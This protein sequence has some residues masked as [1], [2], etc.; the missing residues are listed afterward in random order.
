MAKYIIRGGNKLDGKIEAESA[1][2]AVLPLLA[3]S[4]LTND[5]VVIKNCPHISDVINM[6]NILTELGVNVKFE[7]KN[8]I[9]DAACLNCSRIP[10]YL[11]KKLRSSIF[12]LGALIGR[13][14]KAETSYPGG[15]NIGVRPIDL[16]IKGLEKLGVVVKEECGIIKCK[17]Y[18]LKGTEVFLD[19]PSVGATEN[20]ILASVLASGDTVI[21]NAARE[22][23]IE[24]L[25]NFLNLMGAKISGAGTKT[26]KISGVKKL[27]GIEY[28]PVFDR[29]ETC[30]YLIAALLTGGKVAVSGVN[31]KK[32]LKVLNKFSNNTCKIE[33]NNDII[34]LSADKRFKAFNLK[35]NPY[36]EFPTDLQPQML[37]LATVSNGVSVITET[38]FENR[39]KN[40]D[41]L[42]RMGAV[43]KIENNRAT[44]FGVE[45]LHGA[46]VKSFDLRGG[47]SMILA[48]LNADGV[49]V[50]E[51]E[52]HIER[53]YCNLERKL[54]HLGADIVLIE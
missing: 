42:M 44:V 25:C 19:Y 48:G 40:A 39:F 36:P 23:E 11:A 2:N 32:I 41:E 43:I 29:I 38:V 31:C 34:Y 12:L 28:K 8:L 49:T 1:K 33:A 20:L 27:C 3:A 22:P 51:D 30:T 37:T 15:C 26:V 10:D 21:N 45:R 46:T 18:S 53:G 16:H 5:K 9:V 52:G 50:V 24:D 13:T 4:I 14:G 47:V 35:T 6:V 17:A 7:E 54:R